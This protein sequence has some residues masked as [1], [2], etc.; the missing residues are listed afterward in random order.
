MSRKTGNLNGEVGQITKTFY[1]LIVTSSLLTELITGRQI[2]FK[3]TF[4]HLSYMF[5]NP[6][7]KTRGRRTMSYVKR[8]TLATKKKW[9]IKINKEDVDALLEKGTVDVECF[10]IVNRSVITDMNVTKPT[11]RSESYFKL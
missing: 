7:N 1:T 6:I 10:R 9:T 5:P 8:E 3:P 4:Y 2:C 11:P